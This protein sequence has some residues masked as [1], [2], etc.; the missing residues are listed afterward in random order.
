MHASRGGAQ[1]PTRA[2]QAALGAAD[3]PGRRAG[4]HRGGHPPAAGADRCPERGIRTIPDLLVPSADP[5]SRPIH[6]G[7]PRSCPA[8]WCIHGSCFGSGC[9]VI[10]GLGRPGARRPAVGLPGSGPGR[11]RLR[12]GPSPVSSSTPWRVSGRRCAADPPA[13]FGG[14]RRA[15]TGPKGCRWAGRCPRGR[16]KRRTREH[17]ESRAW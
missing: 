7:K 13:A 1:R 5:D 14:R 4:R 16:R 3:A 17:H 11:R 15:V 6:D 9:W 2:G 10:C 8:Q 12:P